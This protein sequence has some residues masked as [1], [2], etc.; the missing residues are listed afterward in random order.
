[1]TTARRREREIG[2]AQFWIDLPDRLAGERVRGKVHMPTNDPGCAIPSDNS[3][4]VTVEAYIDAEGRHHLVRVWAEGKRIDR[5]VLQGYAD[6]VCREWHSDPPEYPDGSR[7][8]LRDG[9]T[10]GLEV[11][12][13]VAAGRG[14]GR[15]YDQGARAA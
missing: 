1:M 15:G 13:P 14:Y 4:T 9:E 7:C 3:G 8:D 10:I 5:D 11:A 2:Q 12:F 6:L